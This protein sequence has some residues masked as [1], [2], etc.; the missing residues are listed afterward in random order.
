ML[1]HLIRLI[2][3]KRWVGFEKNKLDA[4]QS[5]K[6]EAITVVRVEDRMCKL[7]TKIK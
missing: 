4:I 6:E 7:T 3:N 2:N 1:L 5:L